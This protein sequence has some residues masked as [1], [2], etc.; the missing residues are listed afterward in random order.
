MARPVL[1]VLAGVNGAGKS[2]VGGARIRK[3]GV[4]WYNPDDYARI[5][6]REYG[7]VQQQANSLAWIEGMRRLDEAVANLES[8]A[9]ETTLGGNTVPEKIRQASATHDVLIWYCGLDTPELHLARVRSRVAQGGHDIPTAKIYERWNN[10]LFNLISLFPCLNELLVY[11]NSTQVALGDI[12]PEPRLLLDYCDGKV[13]Y[14]CSKDELAN[15]PVWVQPI[16][17]V[18]L[19]VHTSSD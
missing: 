15:T 5:L 16:V 6:V 8:F 3:Q 11:D 17:E 14:P 1:L 19:E 2:S 12:I 7:L 10:S 13:Q 9:F 4:D 18:A